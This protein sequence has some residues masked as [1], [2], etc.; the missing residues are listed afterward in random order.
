ESIQDYVDA[1]DKPTSDDSGGGGSGS[2]VV[3][4][5]SKNCTRGEVSTPQPESTAKAETDTSASDAGRGRDRW[6]GGRVS[7]AVGPA[8]EIIDWERS[9]AKP[10]DDDGRATV[11][12][13]SQVDP[14]EAVA[15]TDGA[16]SSS[17]RGDVDS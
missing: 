4:A 9:S 8:S 12:Q 1:A 17:V 11:E 5:E 2:H 16:D 14:A 10:D 6:L 15:E 7:N 3:A 13:E